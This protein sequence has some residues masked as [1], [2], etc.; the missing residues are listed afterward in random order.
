MS[1]NVAFGMPVNS[2][3]WH[4][5]ACFIMQIL[6][7]PLHFAPPPGTCTSEMD[8]SSSCKTPTKKSLLCEALPGPL[9]LTRA[10]LTLGSCSSLVSPTRASKLQFICQSSWTTTAWEWLHHTLYLRLTSSQTTHLTAVSECI[11]HQQEAEGP[12]PLLHLGTPY[13]CSKFYLRSPLLRGFLWPLVVYPFR[14]LDREVSQEQSLII[15]ASIA[16]R[17]LPGKYQVTIFKL[18]I[19]M[20]SYCVPECHKHISCIISFI[21]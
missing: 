19:I 2:H 4:L 14:G 17:R 20:N 18:L 5:I 16:P 11:T 9:R 7:K 6:C 12:F 15:L 8:S 1:T 13:M 21:Q 3:K 10:F